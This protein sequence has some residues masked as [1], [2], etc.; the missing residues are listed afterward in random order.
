MSPPELPS[1]AECLAAI[2][3]VQA[4]ADADPAALAA[5]ARHLGS[6][7]K[8]IQRRAAE[9]FAV[10][11]RRG[12][13]VRDVLLATLQSA[14]PHQR[15][16]AAYA[17]SLLGALPPASLPVLVECLGVDDGDVRWAAANIL[18]GMRGAGDVV[19]ALREL[20][21]A[22]NAAQRKMAAYCLRDMDAPSPVAE[23]ALLAA[24]DDAEP[25]V[26]MAAMS[27]L[28]RLS[29]DHTAVARGLIPLLG[30]AEPGVRRAAAATLGAVGERSD[31][32]LAAL[33][34]AAAGPDP[35]LRRAAERS[36]R[37]LEC[38]RSRAR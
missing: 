10:L 11:D 21:R 29:A 16:G 7:H 20:L 12:I 31:V 22:G 28:V 9:A 37:R 25:G 17:L 38:A 33:R 5:L 27:A 2:A 3:A 32:V 24:L 6:R 8:M 19:D 30:D 34:A 4:R 26:R 13:P 1:P 23:R 14:A 18:L 35:S 36:L 15:W